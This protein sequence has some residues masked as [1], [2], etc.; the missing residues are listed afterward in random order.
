MLSVVLCACIARAANTASGVVKYIGTGA[1]DATP[2]VY[3]DVSQVAELV[4]QSSVDDV[5]APQAC[6]AT[7]PKYKYLMNRYAHWKTL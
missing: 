5:S 3:I 2:T 7:N 1:A 4:A 6:P